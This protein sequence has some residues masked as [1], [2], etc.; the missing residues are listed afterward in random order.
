MLSVNDSFYLFG[1]RSGSK[2]STFLSQIG[3]LDLSTKEWVEA[4]LLNHGNSRYGLIFIDS[5]FFVVG[6]HPWAGNPYT[7]KCTLVRVF[8]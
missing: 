8:F 1:G 2:S 4:G 5:S 6:A 3:R 7:E